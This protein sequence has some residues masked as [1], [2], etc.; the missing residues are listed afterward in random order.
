[1]GRGERGS[2]SVH[3]TGAIVNFGLRVIRAIEFLVAV[4]LATTAYTAEAK[5]RL[6]IA[7]SVRSEVA[8]GTV[9]TVPNK[10]FVD[11]GWLQPPAVL[12]VET[13]IYNLDKNKLILAPGT[14][15]AGTAHAGKKVYCTWRHG[16][17]P[18]ADSDL[19]KL[20]IYA[21]GAVVCLS[22]DTA[23]RTVDLFYK[24]SL[25]ALLMNEYRFDFAGDPKHVTSV[26]ATQLMPN[27]YPHEVRFGT[28]LR[29]ERSKNGRRACMFM[30]SEIAGSGRKGVMSQPACFSAVGGVIDYGTARYELLSIS[31]SEAQ[32][33]VL[34]PL[35][36][37]NLHLSA[38]QS[39]NYVYL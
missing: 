37:D 27:D 10:E 28:A 34:K 24:S 8:P 36:F 9:L 21:V 29:I 12:R 26:Q 20:E 15:L 14:L 16:E 3:R 19:A 35:V 39:F 33:R 38:G 30:V 11:G 5:E 22:A 1:M 25:N 31:E 18:I 13:A 32:I 23:G 2:A 4:A 7:W 17:K 6:S